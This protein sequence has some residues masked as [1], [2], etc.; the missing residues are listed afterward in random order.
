LVGKYDFE[1][2]EA[3]APITDPV[4]KFGGQPVWLERPE[5]L[6]S[7]STATRWQGSPALYR[8]TNFRKPVRSVYCCSL[9]P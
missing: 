1:F 5:W 7:C 6:R 4:T 8:L 3:D 2:I 9:T